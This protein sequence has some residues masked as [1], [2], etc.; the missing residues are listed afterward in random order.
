MRS[1][2][3]V[4]A[5]VLVAVYVVSLHPITG[6]LGG[7]VFLLTGWAIPSI[8]NLLLA[9]WCALML[10]KPG[11][12]RW[13]L[14]L[15]ISFTAGLNTSLPALL[16]RAAYTD[17]MTAEIHRR[18]TVN[19][20]TPIDFWLRGDLPPIT[21]D[22]LSSAVAVGSDEGCGCM[23][24]VANESASYYET[25]S[26]IINE[27]T[28][29]TLMTRSDYL[30]FPNMLQRGV[31]FDIDFKNDPKSI[32]TAQLMVTVY[33]G[34]EQTASFLQRGI[35]Y[36]PELSKR[37]GRDRRLLN[38]YFLKNTAS[39]LLHDNFWTLLLKTFTSYVPRGA[40][41]GFLMEAV[42]VT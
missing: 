3:P 1:L 22:P 41:R 34:A 20:D 40:L 24:F 7:L 33:D 5:A 18:V 35:P 15:L 42:H 13:A 10:A 11:W 25:V 6:F 30:Q 17:E 4:C 27:R 9:A 32:G 37:I 29:R 28:R 16:A 12:K 19:A 8:I 23:Y 39:M 14:F 36:D 2:L 26:S 38:G 21:A 31:H